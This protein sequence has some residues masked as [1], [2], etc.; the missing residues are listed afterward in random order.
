MTARFRFFLPVTLP[1][2][3]AD[4]QDRKHRC[5]ERCHFCGEDTSARKLLRC[6]RISSMF[7]YIVLIR[8]IVFD[9]VFNVS[10]TSLLSFLWIY[11][12]DESVVLLCNLFLN[13]AYSLIWHI[14]CYINV[15]ILSATLL[16]RKKYKILV[17]LLYYSITIIF[18]MLIVN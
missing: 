14:D 3:Q 7:H 2:W 12:T 17:I 4:D 9:N 15:S 11:C 13:L 10:L 5:L 16:M 18:I 1:L 6:Y 8:G